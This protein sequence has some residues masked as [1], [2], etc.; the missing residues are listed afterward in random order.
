MWGKVKTLVLAAVVVSAAL[1][2]LFGDPRT[3]PVTHPLWARMLLRAMDMTQAVRASSEASQVFGTL[4]WRDSLTLPAD[5]FVRSDGAVVRDDSGEPVV[6]P[7]E[8]PAEVVYA[9]AVAQAGDYQLRARLAGTPGTLATAEFGPLAGGAPLETFTLVPGN[10]PGWV[11][12]GSAHLDPG[13]YGASVLLP[14]GCTLSQVEVAPPCLNPIEPPGGWQPTGVTTGQDLAIT[15]LKAL[16]ME[17]ELPPA[18][19]PI[20]L[21]AADLQVEA[22]PEAV[23]EQL[24]AEGFAAQALR[25]GHKGLRAIV[26]VDIPQSGLYTVSG[27]VTPGSGQRWL[28]DGCRKA[29]V[30]SGDKTGWRHILSQSFGAG[31]HTL[32][33]SLGPGSE[34]SQV[35]IEKRKD[36]AEDYIGA[37]RRLGLEPGPAE[38]AVSREIAIAAMRFVREQRR[39]AMALLCGDRVVVD[40]TPLPPLQVADDSLPGST[41]GTVAATSSSAP[42]PPPITPPILPPQEP[43]SPTSPTGGG[44]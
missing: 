37:L 6:A 20:D 30:C 32:L 1:V 17:D 31:R 7:R 8:A 38:A 9:V 16:D 39:E 13:T 43:A 33:V 3:T 25:A 26:S 34:L 29:M 21:S 40:D 35:R 27:F 12:G 24:K 5:E 18:A 14:P 11:F 19:S 4:A 15:A 41:E 22:P 2:P 42:A 10:E 36:S 23:E 28:A 44:S